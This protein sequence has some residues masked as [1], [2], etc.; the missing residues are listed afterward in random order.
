MPAHAPITFNV[1]SSLAGAS[2][3]SYDFFS[4]KLDSSL[5]AGSVVRR[6]RATGAG[7]LTLTFDT[8][9]SYQVELDV[10]TDAGGEATATTTVTVL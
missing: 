9:G 2:A 4:T 8:P 3:T 7:G 5:V 10:L 6:A 1:T